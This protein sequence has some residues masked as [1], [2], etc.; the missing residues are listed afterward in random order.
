[1]RHNN[2]PFNVALYGDASGNLF[3][4]HT[5]YPQASTGFHRLSLR[6]TSIATAKQWALRSTIF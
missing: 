5:R 3:T 1:M 6:N 2:V 4:T